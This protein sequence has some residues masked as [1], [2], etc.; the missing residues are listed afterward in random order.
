[1]GKTSYISKWEE[2]RPWLKP[3]KR[4]A[5][6]ACCSLCNMSFNIGIYGVSL[7]KAHPQGDNH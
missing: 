2:V 5:D 6:K 1:M 4:M 7:V 3:V